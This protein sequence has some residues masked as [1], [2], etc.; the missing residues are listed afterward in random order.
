MPRAGRTAI[1]GLRGAAVL[2]RLAAAPV[3]GAANEALVDL[4]ART[5][6]LPRRRFS[7]LTGATG[8]DKRVLIRTASQADV[9]A[10][11]RRALAARPTE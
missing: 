9:A 6:D 10:A 2:I 4:L 3:G 1:A 5:C 8:R 7:I 11:I